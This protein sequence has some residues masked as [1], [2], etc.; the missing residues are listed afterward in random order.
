MN[1]DKRLI[2]NENWKEINQKAMCFVDSFFFCSLFFSL[3][4]FYSRWVMARNE[5]L[6]AFRELDSALSLGKH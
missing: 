5:L 6:I 1:K 2:E 3:S 4:L